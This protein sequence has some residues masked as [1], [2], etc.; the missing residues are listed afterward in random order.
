MSEDQA[1]SKP[2]WI[3]LDKNGN[4]WGPFETTIDANKFGNLKWRP[5]GAFLDW[6]I[7]AL[8]HPDE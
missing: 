8:R 7:V 6:R 5:T 3:V 4:P 1:K 2:L